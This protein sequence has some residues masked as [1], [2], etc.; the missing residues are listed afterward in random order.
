[1]ASTQDDVIDE[2]QR[3][4][5]ELRRENDAALAEKAALAEALARRDSD[6]DERI[7]HQAAT[8]DVL[9]AMSASPGDPQPVFELIAERANTLCN[10]ASVAVYELEDGLVHCR[11]VHGLDPVTVA[12]WRAAFPMAPTASVTACRAILEQR[13]IHY[14]DIEAEP[15]VSEAVKRLG[16]RTILALPLMRDGVAVGSIAL[17]S[18]TPG[19]FSD[20]QVALL[21]TFS[22]QTLIA[23]ASAETYRALRTRTTDLQ[24]AL[25]QQTAT[26][27]VLQVINAS[28]GDLAPVFDAML[29]KAM[30]LCGAAFGEMYTYDGEKFLI[31]S[32]RGVPADYAEFRA[33]NPPRPRSGNP[34]ARLLATRRPV[35]V[36][37]FKDEE[38]FQ[39]GRTRRET[40]ELGGVRTLLLV[41]LIKDDEVL[42]LISVFRQ[43]VRAFSGKEIALLENFAAQAVIAME[44]ARLLGELRQRT[45]DLQESLEYQTATGDMLKVISRSTFDLQPVLEAVVG[46]A[47]RLCDAEQAVIFRRDGASQRL[48]ANFGFPPE[49]EAFVKGM[50]DYRPNPKSVGALAVLAGRPVQIDDVAAVPGY[51]EASIRLGKQR[52]SLAVPLLRESETIGV[53][54]LA[55]QRVAPFT[56]RQIELVST[57][58]DQA[59][60]AIENTRLLTEQQEALEQQTAT[61]D[62]LRVINASPG[63]LQP[64]F[65][66]MLEKA[67]NLCEAS[68]GMLRTFD[69]EYLQLAATINVPEEVLVHWRGPNKTPPSGAQAQ[70][71]GGE[72]FV[73]QADARIDE[74]YLS[75]APP[76]VALVDVAGARTYLTVPLRQ[77]ERLLGSFAIYRQEVRPFTDKQVALLENF[78]AQAVIAMENAR[79]LDELRQRTGDLQESLEYQTAISDVLRVISGSTFDLDPVFQA[80]VTTAVRLCQADQATIYRYHDGEYRWAAGY[81]MTPDSERIEREV[82]IRP[83]TGTLVGRVAL[84]GRTVTILDA[85]TDPLYEVKEDARVSDVRTMLGVPLLRDRVP[86]GVIALARRRVEPFAD[87]QIALVATFADQAVIAIENTR[88]LTEQQEALEQQTATAQVLQVINASP[89]NLTP[90]FDAILEKAMRLCGVAFGSL[91]TWDGQFIHNVANRGLPVALVNFWAENLVRL[92]GPFVQ[93]LIETKR[94]QQYSDLTTAAGYKAE[95]SVARALGD[96]GGARTNLIVPLLK[97]DA[98]LGYFSFFRQ[99]VRAFSDKE[100]ALLE[101][102]AAQ[103]VIAMENARLLTEQQEALEQQTA[104]AEVLQVINASPGELTPVFDA[105]LEKAMRLC[106]AAFGEL[107]TFD[108]ENFH[109]AANRGV[110]TAYAEYRATNPISAKAGASARMLETKRP[111]HVV[112]AIDDW[113]RQ[114]VPG[115][116]AFVDLGGARTILAVPLLKDQVVLGC[117][118]IYR[119][120]VQAYGDK[121]IALLQNFAAQAVIAMENARLITETREALEQQTATAEVLQVINANPGELT[122]VFDAI[123]EKAHSLC[124]APQGS[125][126]IYDGEQFRAVAVRGLPE[127]TAAI[128]RQGYSPPD[129]TSRDRV[130]QVPDMAVALSRNPDNALMRTVVEAGHTRT[131]LHVPLLRDGVLVG[132]ITSGRREVRPFTDKQ[133]ALLENFAAQAVIAMENGRLINETREALEQQTA[134]AEV[135]QLINASPGNLT[136]VFDAILEKAHRICNVAVGSLMTFD[137]THFRAVATRGYGAEADAIVRTPFVPMTGHRALLRGDRLVHAPDWQAY[138]FDADDAGGRAWLA[139]TDARAGVMVPLRKDGVLLGYISSYRLEA[140]PFSDNEVTLLENFAAQAVIA[141]EN[142]RLINETQ[143]ALEQQTAT[144]EVLGIINA[145]PGDLTPVFN[146]ILEKAH[147]L[148]GAVIG[149]L[150]IYDGVNLRALAAHG[151]PEEHVALIREPHSPNSFHRRLIDGEPFIHIPDLRALDL[152]QEDVV[153]S[154]MPANTDVRANLTVPLRKDG[155]FIGYI[156]AFRREARVFSDKEITL[157]E[158][159]AAQAVI[160]MENARLLGEIR[161]RQEELR[162]TFENM[163]DGVAMFDGTQT[164]VAWNRKFQDIL[165]VPDDI[166]AQRRSLPDYVRYLAERGE[167]GSDADVEE[168][169]RRVLATTGQMRVF[170]RMRPNGRVIEIHSN[171]VAGGGFVLIY[172]DIT[173][174]KRN[175]AEIAAARD[176]AQDAARTIEA[177]FRELKTAQA[178]LIQA[179]K[180]AS[181]GQLTAGIAHEIKNPLNFVNNF[182]S[183]SV[184][185][186]AELKE[187]AAPGF[188]LLNDNQRADIDDVSA[189]LTSNLQKITEHGKRADGIVKAMLEHS[190]GASGERRTVD[191]NALTDEALNLAY[192][193]ARAQ[194]QSFNITLERDFGDGIAPIEVNPQD[195]TR[196]LLNLFSNGFYAAN[197]R[198]RN[199]AAAG[200]A[201]TLKVITCA[202]GDAVEIRVRDN[203][204]GIPADIRDKLFQP[205]FT[206]KPTG[207]GTGLGLSITYDIVTKAHGGAISVDSEVDQF[208]EFV[209]TLPRGMFTSAAA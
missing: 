21:R 98:L 136:P 183:L 85:W 156:S 66:A 195:I 89:G 110:P 104:T 45:E 34:P 80:V 103:A 42:G 177:A 199:G 165:E 204:T 67:M 61:A 105:M 19:G 57:F 33:R 114:G 51:P 37:D 127:A 187:A 31:T 126:Q 26:A 182:A 107:Y 87:R 120:E 128:M 18:K 74:G 157:L 8:V 121:Q 171:P 162:I 35:H 15:D 143:E 92:P 178:N 55:R 65:D 73:H 172:S 203:G 153:T 175:E 97:D 20:S 44:N 99:E 54:L 160:A 155:V 2:L 69:G 52:T 94:S 138:P 185:L 198:A 43:E 180:M 16:V 202:A 7:A 135:L 25:E 32:S 30:R 79:L 116:R 131:V 83:G 41:P 169:I 119:Q 56:E 36:L 194:D 197:K 130:V 206:T 13:L 112:D 4:N 72:R 118:L 184:D 140:G 93:Q 50:S 173:E 122:P 39:S 154:R 148:C 144:A 124:A 100:V 102:F 9:K 59:V 90:V 133:I 48:A 113:Y 209:V 192:H 40:T 96:L 10:G 159:F 62:V 47:A 189:M 132:R 191:I 145:S 137:G 149:S 109:A 24:E 12:T 196:V 142:A 46:T 63:N 49:Y 91:L 77:D 106:G 5:A 28:P 68:F 161:Q 123:L 53:L 22:K 146:A 141:M 27:E 179:E 84:E 95:R 76:S 108:G 174:R 117:I 200:F 170:E 147:T 101:N 23:I 188:A 115:A 167:F 151:L 82:S 81:L 38:S 88:L 208:T 14:R 166:I 70:L 6:F 78:A 3:A 190:R 168:Q 71:V 181:L 152:S 150:Q 193:G 86:I 205:F 1:M 134:T 163:G 17:N 201:P 75:G 29:E 64:V 111:V 129:A 186:L 125:L 60:I 207:E 58:A 11:V 139:A 164:L 158:N 176:A